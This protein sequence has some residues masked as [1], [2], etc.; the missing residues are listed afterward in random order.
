MTVQDY[1]YVNVDDSVFD[2]EALLGRVLAG[3]PTSM[4]IEF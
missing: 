3:N 2:A 1:Y 4:I